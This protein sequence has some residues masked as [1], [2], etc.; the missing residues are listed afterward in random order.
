MS[1]L[2][3]IWT[4][5]SSY[6]QEKALQHLPVQL[7]LSG[8]IPLRICTHGLGSADTVCPLQVSVELAGLAEAQ[9]NAGRILNTS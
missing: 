6:A 3:R 8:L 9:A 2:F 1:V 7:L 5:G 4:D